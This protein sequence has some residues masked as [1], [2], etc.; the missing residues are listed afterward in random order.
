MNTQD[1]KIKIAVLGAGSIG[2]YIGGCLLEQGLTV[3]F[4]GRER[5]FN[6][7]KEHGLTVTD[8]QGKNQHFDLA[9]DFNFSCNNSPLSDADFVFV[10]VKSGDTEQAAQLL[11]E[12]I[13]ENVVVVSFQNG[14][15]NGEILQ[16]YLPQHKVLSAIVGFNVINK[17]GGHF[18]C[19]SEGEV[20]IEDTDQSA[21]LIIDGLNAANVKTVV[22]SDLKPL[23]WG[24]LLVNLNNAVN[25]L[26]GV[27]LKDQL[28][29]ANYRQVVAMSI[30]EAVKVLKKANIKPAKMGKVN[31]LIMPII[32][33]LPNFIFLRIAKSAIKVDP[34]ARS[35]MYEDLHFGRKTEIDYLNGEIVKLGHRLKIATPVNSAIV[36]LVKSAESSGK[37]VPNIGAH[38]LLAS[39]TN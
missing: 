4:I 32:F 10:A 35:S 2:S 30:A 23:L 9:K 19:A 18:H 38:Q 13:K 31:P 34:S 37:G 6:Q 36:S 28:M 33:K 14:L 5:M 39:I 12:T 27:P 25:A 15:T 3:D 26:A 16:K 11:A 29:D 21:K 22:Y 17:G 20:A 8:W 24:K 7:I 1:N